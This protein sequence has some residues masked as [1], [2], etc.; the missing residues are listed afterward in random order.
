MVSWKLIMKEKPPG[1]QL[2][3]S[4][5]DLMS[6]VNNP[7]YL[8]IDVETLSVALAVLELT[9]WNRLALDS[10]SLLA[11]PFPWVLGILYAPLDHANPKYL[12]IKKNANHSD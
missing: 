4:I 12:K 7:K 9:A 6:S 10:Q 3:E 8:F 11:S 1:R 5:P 2:G